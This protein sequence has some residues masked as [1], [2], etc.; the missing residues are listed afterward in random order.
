MQKMA[1]N[2]LKI[3]KLNPL[4]GQLWIPMI[5]MF[6]S[7]QFTL[8]KSSWLRNTPFLAGRTPHQ[9]WTKS[10]FGAGGN[11]PSIFH[12]RIVSVKIFFLF[13]LYKCTLY[14][15]KYWRLKVLTPAFVMRVAPTHSHYWRLL[16][17]HCSNVILLK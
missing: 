14:N 13:I 2:V 8:L 1:T 9:K 7:S 6:F 11:H 4:L 15:A 10:S 17:R 16:S 3:K 5:L 12:R